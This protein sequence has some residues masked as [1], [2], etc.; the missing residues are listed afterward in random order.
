M[1][2]KLATT[3]S[4]FGAA[5]ASMLVAP[6]LQAQTVST[7]AMN[8]GSIGFN[9]T[10]SGTGL[11]ALSLTAVP[12]SAH[13]SQW[14]DYVGRTMLLGG[15]GYMVS[16]GT[17][18]LSQTLIA[19]VGNWAYGFSPPNTASGSAYLGFQTVGGNLG[20]FHV[21][22]G[23]FGAPIVYGKGGWDPNGGNVHV[24]TVPAPGALALLAMGAVG[25]RRKRKRA[26]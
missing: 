26:A 16:F 10:G 25:I 2:V 19:G 5:L 21:S 24:G 8:P 4:V 23:G 3:A 14:N 6:E 22:F 12:G 15:G 17:V 1:E 11:V 9:F 13:F 18:Q 7:G 20:W